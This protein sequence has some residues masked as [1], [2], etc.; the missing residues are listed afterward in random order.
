[1]NSVASRRAI[2]TSVVVTHSLNIH[3]DES[4]WKTQSHT[5]A[6]LDKDSSMPRALP[7]RAQ[8]QALKAIFKSTAAKSKSP[9]T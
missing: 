8:A 6:R 4:L 3:A 1:M 9:I 7:L 5:H 2:A